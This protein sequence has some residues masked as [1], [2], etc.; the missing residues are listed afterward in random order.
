MATGPAA[1]YGI[2]RG[3]R[4]I[5]F[6]LIFGVALPASALVR[7]EAYSDLASALAGDTNAVVRTLEAPYPA[8][9][10]VHNAAK[11]EWRVNAV[12]LWPAETPF[13]VALY[14]V[15]GNRIAGGESRKSMFLVSRPRLWS[16]E[17]P[18]NRYTLMFSTAEEHV[19]VPFGFRIGETGD[20][21]IVPLDY[22]DLSLTDYELEPR[23]ERWAVEFG[24]EHEFS[25]VNRNSFTDAEGVRCRWEALRNG[26][27]EFEGDVEVGEFGPGEQVTRKV[28][29]SVDRMIRER[30]GEVILAVE[31][32]RG[33]RRLARGE[34]VF[35][36]RPERLQVVDTHDGELAAP[37]WAET[38][39][40][41]EFTTPSLKVVFDK[42]TGM[43]AGFV[44]RGR[45]R[46]QAF[47][48]SSLRPS[49]A[50]L[51]RLESVE[52]EISGIET[53]S[54][55]CRFTTRTEWRSALGSRL[56]TEARWFVRADDMLV[57]FV[58]FVSPASAPD[59]WSLGFV[60]APGDFEFLGRDAD[61][62]LRLMSEVS[63][64]GAGEVGGFR[65]GPF[66]VRS[67]VLPFARVAAVDG[68]VSF[69]AAAD[70]LG[71]TFS[72]G[73]EELVTRKPVK[74]AHYE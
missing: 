49:L 67:L 64:L 27:R 12:S 47:L 14:D 41:F 6:G 58:R 4:G 74:A 60:P 56:V 43:P 65:V 13:R 5:V 71:F 53:V 9:A 50:A 61:G 18:A 70:E 21:R 23:P 42:L 62:R 10:D 24:G 16:V 57:G 8:W 15:S 30:G 37:A 39:D 35:R 33:E 29:A 51:S 28:P 17:Q 2:I 1:D 63:P 11:N 46:D 3:M 32:W 22:K 52:A 36:C 72:L 48:A 31:L 59:G 54:G 25:L 45:F 40:A 68:A 26:I 73:D 44:R 19:P 55:E 34:R 7:L 38:E 66:A 69:R 20:G